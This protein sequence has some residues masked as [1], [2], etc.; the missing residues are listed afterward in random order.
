LSASLARAIESGGRNIR[1]QVQVA[2]V[3][4]HVEISAGG[5]VLQVRPI[6]HD[7]SRE[8]G[9]FDGPCASR[10]GSRHGPVLRRFTSPQAIATPLTYHQ[11]L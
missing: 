9:A 7:C 1:R 10:N 4:E 8:H 6:R 11:T 2:I 3:G 5:D